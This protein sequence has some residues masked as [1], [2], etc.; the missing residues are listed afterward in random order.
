MDTYISSV[1]QFVDRATLTPIVRQSLRCDTFQIQ[2]WQISQLGGGAGNPVSVGLYRFDG[3]GKD[4]GEPVAWSV[5]LKVLQSPTNIGWLNMGEGE[6][7]AHW[8]Y[9]KRELYVYQSGWLDTLPD[10]MA[11]P[12]CFGIIEQPG[13]IAWIWLEDITDY[14]GGVWSLERYALTARH[15]GRLNG[16][17]ITSRPL[18]TYAWLGINL[19]QQ[20]GTAFQS[21]WQ[22]LP[23]EHLRVL[24]RYPRANSFHRLL[25]EYE[26]FQAKLNLL[27][28]TICHGDTYPTNLMS[29]RLVDGQD[30]TVALD[31]ALVNISAIGD[32]LGQFIYGAH[33]KLKGVT[34]KNIIQTLFDSYIEGIRDSGCHIEPKQ[35]QFGFAASA[36]LRVGLFQVYLLSEELKRDHDPAQE[37]VDHSNTTDCFEVALADKAWELLG[38]F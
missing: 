26:Q 31:W 37:I 25:L 19:I 4:H 21:Q 16:M 10:G 8:N 23:W 33:M 14:F 11:A 28:R 34:L 30:Q 20:W 24:A 32:D 12:R 13:N 36:A 22:S 2:D 15:L 7:Q 35:V 5:I 27:P 1:L 17:Y 18:P 6:N 9:W 3:I 29:H 38:A